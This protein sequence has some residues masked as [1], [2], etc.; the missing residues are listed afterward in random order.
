MPRTAYQKTAAKIGAK[1]PRK[2]VAAK[3][4]PRLTKSKPAQGT[5]RAA[6]QQTERLNGTSRKKRVKRMK[7]IVAITISSNSES[8]YESE[9]MRAGAQD[10]TP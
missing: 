10:E 3:G 9:E 4:P 6:T 1:C 5:L 2:R 8:S 7:E